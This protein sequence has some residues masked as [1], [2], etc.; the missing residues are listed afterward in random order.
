MLS[1][2]GRSYPFDARGSGYGRGE[3]A[4]VVLLKRLDDAI[5]AGDQ[6]RAIIR[7]SGTNQ[8]GRT[9]GITLPSQEAQECLERSI[10]REVG[11]DSHNIPYI[12]THGTGTSAGDLAE[13]Q[14][15]ANVFCG[16]GRHQ[17][18]L[19][20]GSIKSNIGHLESSSGLAGLIKTV[21]ILEK[22]VIPPNA[23]FQSKKHNLKLE[24]WNMKVTADRSSAIL[25]Y[26][27][28][29]RYRR[30][31]NPGQSKGKYAKPL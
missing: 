15:I 21:L 4:S 7:G 26:L 17:S 13:L 30:S 8:D 5:Q 31:S 20:I 29:F 1:D 28:I 19:Y 27:T 3:G 18:K 12:E 2:D 16:N 10:Y 23:D 9:N 25:Y 6:V 11:L 14:N 24:E 22:G